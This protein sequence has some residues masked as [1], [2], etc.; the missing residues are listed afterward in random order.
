[1]KIRDKGGDV[2]YRFMP[3][4]DLLPLVLDDGKILDGM[5]LDEYLTEKLPELPEEAT[6]RLMEQYNLPEDVALVITSD[7]PAIAMYEDTIEACVAYLMTRGDD[8]DDDDSGSKNEE[9]EHAS[10][11]T[12]KVT[13]YKAPNAVANWLCNDLFALVKESATMSTKEDTTSQHSKDTNQ[14]PA[15]DSDDNNIDSDDD[16]DDDVVV[17][18]NHPISME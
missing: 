15:D 1:V 3:E 18:L 10:S 5:T 9:Q 2:E 8:D 7:R 12:K 16:D 14:R 13:S 11:K 17:Q 4:P 6:T